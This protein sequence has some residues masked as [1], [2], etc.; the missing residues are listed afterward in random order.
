[1]IILL[2]LQSSI[3]Y[4]MQG[5]PGRGWGGVYSYPE[6]SEECTPLQSPGRGQRW[7]RSWVTDPTD[8]HQTPAEEPERDRD[9]QGQLSHTTAGVLVSLSR[10]RDCQGQ[11]RCPCLI[12]TRPRLSR[13]AKSHN[14]WC[15]CLIVTRPRPSR[16]AKSHNSWCPCLIVI[17]FHSHQQNSCIRRNHFQ[18]WWAMFVNYQN[19]AGSVLILR[20]AGSLC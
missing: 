9:C 7:E 20:V 11:L 17:K 6:D 16:S 13:S 12:I 10:D 2:I 14:S 1:M 8:Q 18:W 19:F 4:L 5:K 15:P 3:L